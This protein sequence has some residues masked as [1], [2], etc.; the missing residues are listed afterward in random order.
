MISNLKDCLINKIEEIKEKKLEIDELNKK[1]DEL[2]GKRNELIKERDSLKKGIKGLFS[3]AKINEKNLEN[4][5]ILNEQE[6][7]DKEIEKINETIKEITLSNRINQIPGNTLEDKKQQISEAK[8]LDSLYISFEEAREILENNGYEFIL[9]ESDKKIMQGEISHVG[10][11]SGKGI[12]FIRLTDSMPKDNTIYRRIDENSMQTIKGKFGEIHIPSSRE[13]THLSACSEVAN[14]DFSGWDNKK[15][16]IIIPLTDM[17]KNLKI[18]S[19]SPADFQIKGKVPI[20]SS[21]W[22]ICPKSQVELARQNNPGCNIMPYEGENVRGFANTLLS[23]LGYTYSKV[24]TY[25]FENMNHINWYDTTIKEYF[26]LSEIKK[27]YHNNSKEDIEEDVGRIGNLFRAFKEAIEKGTI[28]YNEETKEEIKSMINSS[29]NV[30]ANWDLYEA[31][32]LLNDLNLTKED[33]EGIKDLHHPDL[34][35]LLQSKISETLDITAI[36][37]TQKGQQNMDEIEDQTGEQTENLAKS[38]EGIELADLQN[39]REQME[40]T[41]SQDKDQNQSIQEEEENGEH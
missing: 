18:T 1:H 27:G 8:F 31:D 40:D 6:A 15:I 25:N 4:G 5:N 21:G 34:V 26:G 38:Y 35:K 30:N 24:T 9:D 39:A 23:Y 19:Y 41:I 11:R 13:T 2:D 37:E 29:F 20:P 3:R 14:V 33:I 32:G 28:T 36:R 7:I 22:I 17:S 10:N 12:A 16:A